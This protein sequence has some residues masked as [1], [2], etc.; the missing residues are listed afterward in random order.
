MN[1]ARDACA[2]ASV[3]SISSALRAAAF[4]SGMA[5][6]GGSPPTTDEAPA[7]SSSRRDR[8]R[9]PRCRDRRR[10]PVGN[11]ERLPQGCLGPSI[12]EVAAPQVVLVG[13]RPD[14]TGTRETGL[15]L[16]RQRHRD[17]PGDGP[18]DLALQDQHVAQLA[19]IGLGPDVALVDD[20]YELSGDPHALAGAP[21][22]ALEDVVGPQLLADRGMSR[23]AR[24]YFQVELRA[25]TLSRSGASR[26]SCVII[27][28][29]RPSLRY[30]WSASPERLSKGRTASVTFC[31]GW[32]RGRGRAP[33]Q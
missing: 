33:I 8:C 4:A 9:R 19:V 1:L 21:E 10:P 27:S 18:G 12:E 2:S 5:T 15:R 6:R 7:T 24:L 11:T 17:G 29:V 3:P 25:V 31:P 22:A 28:S 23:S 14:R 16:G 30:S 20:L 26:A 32:V 13:L